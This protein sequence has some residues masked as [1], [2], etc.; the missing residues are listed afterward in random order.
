M[1]PDTEGNLPPPPLS[2]L[3]GDPLTGPARLSSRGSPAIP[4]FGAIALHGPPDRTTKHPEASYV[5]KCCRSTPVRC[6]SAPRSPSATLLGSAVGSGSGSG[7]P[8]REW[9]QDHPGVRRASLH[10]ERGLGLGRDLSERGLHSG[11]PLP[12]GGGVPAAR[13]PWSPAGG[14]RSGDGARCDSYPR[15]LRSLRRSAR[16]PRQLDP[17]AMDADPLHRV[18]GG[19]GAS[20]GDASGGGGDRPGVAHLRSLL[21]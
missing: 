6:L 2:H 10:A 13:A 4:S 12:P 1:R 17:R 21:R 11:S 15:P 20:T 3:E 9:R 19:G 5:Q 18:D 8:R 14:I 16:R 7:L